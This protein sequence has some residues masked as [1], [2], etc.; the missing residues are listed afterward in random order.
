MTQPELADV[1]VPVPLRWRH[2]VGGDVI[3]GTG[4]VPWMVDAT[5]HAD[6]GSWVALARAAHD[7][8]GQ[9]DPDE[10]VQVLVLA[11]ERDALTVARDQLGARIVES[12]ADAMA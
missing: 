5:A 11:T 7:W 9:V 1:W 12:R 6:D 2:V 10:V 8:R 4:G 3:I